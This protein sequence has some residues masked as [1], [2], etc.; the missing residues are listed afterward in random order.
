MANR[1]SRDARKQILDD[2]ILVGSCSGGQYVVEFVKRVFPDV[3]DM[4]YQQGAHTIPVI[5]DISRHMDVFSEDWD[6][7]YLFDTVLDLL[8]VADDK[9]IY[10]CEEYVNPVFRRCRLDENE[11][12]IDVTQE[13]IDAINRGLSDIGMS[14]QSAGQTTCIL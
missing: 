12:W 14:L 13:C 10:F 7:T 6:F 3:E 5:N 4:T 11:E 1:I 8:N 2:L 9:F